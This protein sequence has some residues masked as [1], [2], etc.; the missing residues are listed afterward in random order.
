MN[1][2]ARWLLH[3]WY[4]PDPPVA[5]SALAKVFSI[6]VKTRLLLY[7]LGVLKRYVIPCRTVVV[8]NISVG[9]NGKTPL[10]MWLAQRLSAS[11]ISVGIVSRG[12]KGS[13][14][15]PKLVGPTSSFSEVG[16]EAIL[17]ARRAGVPV[18]VCRDRVEAARALYEKFKP[19]IILSDDGLQHYRLARD[20]EIAAIDSVEGLGN[21]HLL[22]AGPLREP[23]ARLRSVD[24]IV[25]K[26]SGKAQLM[27]KGV[28]ILRMR[29]WIDRAISLDN[30][31]VR[32]LESF[33]DDKVAAVAAIAA[34]DRFF[35]LL[36]E[37][38]LDVEKHGLMDHSAVANYLDSLPK[39]R[40]ILVTEK[41][42]A[43]LPEGGLPHVWKVPLEVTFSD[44]DSTCLQKLVLGVASDLCGGRP[45]LSV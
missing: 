18:I 35:S 14:R 38:G 1:G 39:N 20:L 16:D 27:P 37:H 7:E 2:F 33:R 41:D 12:Y 28:P 25:L 11:G 32:S 17:L 23:P 22:P 44:E 19:Q 10:V 24:A 34:P 36:A 31:E 8:G 21:R 30:R 26:G 6:L 43:K 45:A 9:G 29:C 40:T 3:Q 15:Y 4:S 13:R 5:L 42:A